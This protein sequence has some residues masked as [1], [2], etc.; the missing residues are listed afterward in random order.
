[1][2]HNE[3][4]VRTIFEAEAT[5]LIHSEKHVIIKTNLIPSIMMKKLKNV[6]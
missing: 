4:T 3:V 6:H 1:M 2:L 5:E